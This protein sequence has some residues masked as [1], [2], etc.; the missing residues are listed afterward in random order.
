MNNKV[1][2]S[3]IGLIAVAGLIFGVTAF[4][5]PVQVSSVKTVVG[6]KGEKGD[7]GDK[8]DRG[9]QGLTGQS[10]KTVVGA[11][12][13]PDTY[14]PYVAN[15]DLQKFG[16][17]RGLVTATTTVCAI[18]SPVSTSTLDFA[19][20][21]FIVGS[22]T[23]ATIT[24]AKAATP[25]ATT[26]ILNT[27]ALAANA[28]GTFMASSTNLFATGLIGDV[29]FAPSQWFVVGMAGGIGTFSPVG[30]CSAEFIRN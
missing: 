12:A 28:Q 13:G 21:K 3:I 26:T 23:A 14:F 30:S 5:K 22:T 11:V 25:F 20:V 18:Q 17:T 19:S 2:T 16:Q 8:G 10:G 27:Q 24:L 6:D 1:I 15:N 4:N 9:I 7:K 29:I